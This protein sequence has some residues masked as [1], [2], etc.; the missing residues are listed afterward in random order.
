MKKYQNH[1]HPVPVTTF[2]H[3]DTTARTLWIPAVNNHAAYGRW[4]FVEITDPWDAK[5]TLRA[6]LKCK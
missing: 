1:Y 4:A 3:K 2:K 5:N 6:A